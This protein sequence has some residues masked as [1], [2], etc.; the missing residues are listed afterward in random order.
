MNKYRE[1][2]E[3][4]KKELEERLNKLNEFNASDEANE[5]DQVQKSISRIQAGAMYTYLECLKEALARL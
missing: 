5:I 4:E 1:N 2:L 3:A